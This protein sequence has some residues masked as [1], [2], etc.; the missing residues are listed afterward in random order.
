MTDRSYLQLP[1]NAD[2]GFPQAFRLSFAGQV[3][4]ILLYVNV[5]EENRESL[6]ELPTSQDAAQQAFMVMRVTRDSAPS[7]TIFQR[8]LVP[9]LEYRAAELAFVFRQMRVARQNLNGIGSF[10][11]A[12]VGGVALWDS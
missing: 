6:L 4:I 12:V 8:K 2:Q 11:S 5:P 9:N 7:G 1:I 10:G 3:Y